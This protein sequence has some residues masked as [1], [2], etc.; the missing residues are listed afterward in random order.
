VVVVAG[1]LASFVYT[2]AASNP[3]VGQITRVF[4]FPAVMVGRHA[5]SFQDYYNEQSAIKQYFSSATNKAATI[6][7]EEMSAIAI[8]TLVNKTVVKKLASDYSLTLDSSRVED[9]YQKL[10]EAGDGEEA[11]KKQLSETFGWTPDDFKTSIVGSLILAMQVGEFIAQNEDLQAPQKTLIDEAYTRVASG[12]DFAVVA[13]EVHEKA[14]VAMDSDL[15]FINASELPLSWSENVTT[16]ETGKVSEVVELPEGYAFFS[17]SERR[18]SGEKEEIH[19]L[20]VTVP[21]KNLEQVVGEYLETVKVRKM[22][23]GA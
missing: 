15:G 9:Y 3:R 21:K 11:F 8:N 20:A 14:R 18:G 17:V 10:I 2:H 7:D 4:P 19:L 23:K 1:A 5:V 16:L 22:I 12:E 6:S 13:K